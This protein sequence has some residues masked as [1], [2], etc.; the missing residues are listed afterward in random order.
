[1]S[2]NSA[3]ILVLS[4]AA[5]VSIGMVMLFSASSYARDSH[6]DVYFFLKRQSLWLALGI[7]AC[8]LATLID[9][10]FWARAWAPLFLIAAVLLALCFVPHI[11]L[12]LNGSSRWVR[13]GPLV[14]Q[15]SEVGKLAAIVAL[16][17]WFTRFEPRS[18]Q[19][20]HGFILPMLLVGVLMGLI[21][22]EEDLGT[23]LL[24]G[25][26]MVAVMFVAGSNPIYM[27]LLAIAGFAGI[28]FIATHMSQRMARLDAFFDLERTKEGA[29]LQQWEALKA[30]GSGGLWGLGLGESREKFQYLPYAHTDF[31]FPIIGEELGLRATLLIVL[32][33]LLVTLSGTLIALQAR[34]RFGMLLGF[35]LVANIALQASVNIGMTTALLPNK[36][37]PLPFISAGGS[38]LCLCLLFVGVLL[39]IYRQGIPQD[40]SPV[41]NAA[42]LQSRTTPRL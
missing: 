4:V 20:L 31:I 11:G 6:G 10:H 21:V 30:L 23:T 42:R 16:A 40:A 18:A 37:M 3:R 38:N 24:I 29:G 19:F 25:A 1:M 17:W 14:F 35:G 2:K 39:N 32:S 13:L 9:Y 26:T 7:V 28:L 41:T 12:R 34:D 15:P 27:T 5:L 22:R 36:G 8:V 33:F